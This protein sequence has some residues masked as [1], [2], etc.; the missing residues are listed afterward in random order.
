MRFGGCGGHPQ[1]LS[2]DAQ[3]LDII[4][5]GALLSMTKG[6][7]SAARSPAGE[8]R[9]PIFLAVYALRWQHVHIFLPIE[10]SAARRAP[11]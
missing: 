7:A 5:G 6:A 4:V 2:A 9:I 10:R 3:L 1:G 8:L 11:R